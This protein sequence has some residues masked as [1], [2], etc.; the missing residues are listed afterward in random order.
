[1]E[2]TQVYP[3]TCDYIVLHKMS[4]IYIIEYYLALKKEQTSDKCKTWVSLKVIM[5]NKIN[6][7]KKNMYSMIALI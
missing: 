5:M 7:T 1:M 6:L 4:Y 3:S 2:I